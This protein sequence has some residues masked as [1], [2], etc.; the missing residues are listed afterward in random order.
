MERALGFE[1]MVVAI[2]ALGLRCG[3]LISSGIPEG[4]EETP[5]MEGS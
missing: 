2:L 3:E 5:H 4:L 1:L